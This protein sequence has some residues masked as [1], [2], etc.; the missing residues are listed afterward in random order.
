MK[1]VL[2]IINPVSGQKRI[3]PKLFYIV[4]ALC[5]ADCNVTVYTTQHRGHASELSMS[6]PIVG[7]DTIICCG[8]DG[9]LNETITGLCM[10]NSRSKINLGYIP[11]GSTNDFADTLG[12]NT[13]PEKQIKNI[14]KQNLTTIDVGRFGD[15]RFFSYIASFGA[16]TDAAYSAPQDLKNAF[17]HF[18]YILEGLK[19]ISNIKPINATVIAD[20]KEYS[21]TYVFGSVSNTKSVAGIV[22]LKD[23][24]VDLNDGLFE[25]LL[26]KYPEDIIDLNDILIGASM[27]NFDSEM[28]EF[29]RA[30]ELSFRFERPLCWTLDGEQSNASKKAEIKV[31]EKA[32]NLYV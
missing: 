12:L 15:R 30:K 21:G 32:V 3:Q 6:A 27:S 8:G 14:L 23:D 18:A 22:K 31:M 7:Y 19:D 24:V 20:G 5:E 13:S 2:L 16:L 25:V 1:N 11:C 10:S 26:V 4:N 17:G 9:T 28:F 29:F